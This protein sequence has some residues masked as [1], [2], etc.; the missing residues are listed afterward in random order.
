MDL[1]K[2]RGTPGQGKGA[3]SSSPDGSKDLPTMGS[4]EANGKKGAKNITET[5]AWKEGMGGFRQIWGNYIQTLIVYF[6]RMTRVE[7]ESLITRACQV[8]TVGCAIVLTTF[9]YQFIPTLIRVFALP[10]FIVGSWFVATRVVAP[11]V[12]AQFENKL[13]DS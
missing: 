3:G 2:L 9:F 4:E 13:N 7:Q 10:A 12:I 8:I 1:G 11:I 5:K 6:K